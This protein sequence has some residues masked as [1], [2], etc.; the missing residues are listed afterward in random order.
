MK[1][2]I[3][4]ASIA[5]NLA[6]GLIFWGVLQDEKE[7]RAHWFREAKLQLDWGNSVNAEL[8]KCQSQSK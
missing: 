7:A 1:N 4:A 3:L 2:I 8:K 5:L 6:G